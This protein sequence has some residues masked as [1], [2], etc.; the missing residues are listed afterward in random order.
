MA[1]KPPFEITPEILTFVAEIE[2]LLG[3]VDASTAARPEPRLRKQNR[4]CTIKDSLAIEGNTLSLEQVTALFEKKRVVG[5]PK[6][7]LEVKNAIRAYELAANWRGSRE[8]DFK[9]AHGELMQGLLARP[10]AYRTGSVGML[11]GSKVSHLAP[12]HSRLPELMGKLFAFLSGQKNKLSPLILSAVAHY[13]IEFIHPF[14]DGN[15]RMGRLWSHV[16]LRDYH[17]AFEVV[18]IESLIRENQAEYYHVLE[19]CDRAGSSTEFIEF[20]LKLLVE[21]VKGLLDA[22]PR[23]RLTV[24]ERLERARDEFSGRWF[25]RKDYRQLFPGISGP[26]ASRDL[27]DG[28]KSKAL[29]KQGKL[30]KTEYMF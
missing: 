20:S 17:P 6:D 28:V 16:I 25:T 15:G 9:K 19:K 18:P 12:P 11:K 30:N 24:E 10:G 1:T 7:I 2:R 8:L 27:A 21:A 23:R 26:T 13:E 3:K 14:E 4:I 22:A 5:P 29:A